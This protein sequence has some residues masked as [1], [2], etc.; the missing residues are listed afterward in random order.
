MNM[1]QTTFKKN[2]FKIIR[3]IKVQNITVAT[4]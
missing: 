1:L 2:G 4:P 3:F